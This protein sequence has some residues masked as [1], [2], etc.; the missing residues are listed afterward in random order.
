MRFIFIALIALA[1]WL[2]Q[3]AAQAALL[4]GLHLDDSED[5]SSYRTFLISFRKGKGQLAADIS[6]LIVPRK[7]G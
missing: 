6:D 1:L 7:N 3:S 5:A 4:V 2:P